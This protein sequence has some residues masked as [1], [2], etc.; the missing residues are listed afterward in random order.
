MSGHESG[1]SGISEVGLSERTPL[2]EQV[3]A[4]EHLHAAQPAYWLTMQIGV[5]SELATSDLST[6]GSRAHSSTQGL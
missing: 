3:F 5:L 4:P 2:T 1:P 6:G